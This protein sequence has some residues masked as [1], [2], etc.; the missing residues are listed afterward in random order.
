MSKSKYTMNDLTYL[1]LGSGEVYSWG[2]NDHG[3][4]GTGREPFHTVVHWTP[5]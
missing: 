2:S 4:C 3:Q 5:K 1:L